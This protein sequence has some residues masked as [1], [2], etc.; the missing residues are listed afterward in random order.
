MV[1]LDIDYDNDLSWTFT[2]KLDHQPPLVI[3]SHRMLV[4]PLPF[5]LLKVKRF[6]SVKGTLVR[7]PSNDLHSMPERRDD[8]GRIPG[9][10]QFVGIE[11]LQIA[12][13]EPELHVGDQPG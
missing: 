8:G 5:E 12:A 1:V 11:S 7:R 3:E 2:F 9:C 13:L 6:Q 4:A 10:I